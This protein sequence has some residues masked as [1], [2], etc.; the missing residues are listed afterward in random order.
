MYGTVLKRPFT[1]YTTNKSRIH[2]S[3]EKRRM[4]EAGEKNMEEDEL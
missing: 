3:R 2:I 4:T 1:R